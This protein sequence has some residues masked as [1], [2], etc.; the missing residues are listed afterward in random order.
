ML[1]TRRIQVRNKMKSTFV[2]MEW[3]K[4][5]VADALLQVQ[6]M[7][8]Y[9]SPVFRHTSRNPTRYAAL[10]QGKHVFLNTQHYL[11]FASKPFLMCY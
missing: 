11:L 3:I 4:S 8:P 9:S 1:L 5:T 10:M 6:V 7:L 2:E